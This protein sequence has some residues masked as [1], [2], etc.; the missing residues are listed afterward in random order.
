MRE[1]AVTEGDKVEAQIRLGYTVH[2][3][4]VGDLVDDGQQGTEARSTNA[5]LQEYEASMTLAPDLRSN[6]ALASAWCGKQR[7]SNLACSAFPPKRRFQGI[8]DHFRGFAWVGATAG[9]GRP[10][11][12]GRRLRLRRGRRLENSRLAAG[13][14]SHGH[15]LDGGTS[16]MEDYT[17]HLIQQG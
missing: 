2:G 14:E 7:G 8:Y 6:G 16:F 17:Y 11:V 3:Y 10:A 5:L 12:D 1:V 9:A 4:G 13:N 15:R